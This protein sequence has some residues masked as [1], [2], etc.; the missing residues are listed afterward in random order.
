VKHYFRLHIEASK[1]GPAVDPNISAKVA[2]KARAEV[3]P[4]A[5]CVPEVLVG[6]AGFG[7]PL[8]VLGVGR[9]GDRSS[10]HQEQG[11]KQVA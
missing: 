3:I 9:D 4:V 5:K 7:A 10:E 8:Q 11:W 2:A 1:H 6:H